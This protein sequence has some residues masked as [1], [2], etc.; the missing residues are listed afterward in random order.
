MSR[1]A[2]ARK[3]AKLGSVEKIFRGKQG[4]KRGIL[5]Y[6]FPQIYIIFLINVGY[7]RTVF[8]HV[9]CNC[10]YNVMQTLF[11]LSKCLILI[12]LLKFGQD[13]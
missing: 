10:G 2:A 11:W 3:T 8:V 9:E 1:A 7:T 13:S 4:Q 12:L 6:L 5:F